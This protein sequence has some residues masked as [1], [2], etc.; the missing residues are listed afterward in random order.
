MLSQCTECSFVIACAQH[1]V[2]PVNKEG[3]WNMVRY[4][5]YKLTSMSY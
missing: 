4:T 2:K 3:A 5:N 1:G